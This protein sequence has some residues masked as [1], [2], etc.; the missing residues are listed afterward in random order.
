MTS[1]L[2]ML[3]YQQ[4]GDLPSDQAPYAEKIFE[5]SPLSR[6]LKQGAPAGAAWQD[7]EQVGGYGL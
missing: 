5:R 3:F 1:V 6:V 4:A 2:N 7:V